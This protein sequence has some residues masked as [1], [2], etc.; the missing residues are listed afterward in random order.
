M[1]DL[2]ST[3]FRGNKELDAVKGKTVNFY[4]KMMCG[5]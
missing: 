2:S 1:Y 3:W 4:M 5:T